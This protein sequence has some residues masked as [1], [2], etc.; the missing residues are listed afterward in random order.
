MAEKQ[1]YYLHFITEIKI[2]CNFHFQAIKSFSRAIHLNP[3]SEELWQDDLMWA[4]DL[5]NKRSFLADQT[6][7]LLKAESGCKITEIIDNPPIGD[8]S[9]IQ[10]C[11]KRSASEGCTDV[12]KRKCP[13]HMSTVNSVQEND[14]CANCSCGGVKTLKKLPHNY[15][16][17]RD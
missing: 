1:Q 6:A 17:M 7:R 10:G 5:L 3:T 12:V 11:S 4:V 14:P 15:V 2:F 13:A 9:K 16:C 8:E